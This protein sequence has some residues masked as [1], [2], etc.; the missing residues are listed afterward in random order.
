MPGRAYRSNDLTEAWRER[1]GSIGLEVAVFRIVCL[2][3]VAESVN[4]PPFQVVE[5]IGLLIRGRP[6]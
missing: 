6:E 3:A 2:R 4:R 1:A 5:V